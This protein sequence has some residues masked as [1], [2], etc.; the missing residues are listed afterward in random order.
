MLY[1]GRMPD[2]T[3]RDRVLSA[4]CVLEH[5]ADE[6]ALGGAVTAALCGHWDHEG[7]CRWPHHNE[8]STDADGITHV[9]T[10]VTLAE[11]D[12]AEV[13]RR[14]HDALEAGELTGPDGTVSRW[15]LVTA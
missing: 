9:R 2:D 5:D 3:A 7:P 4:D 14:F 15:R 12:D 11:A 10:T 8:S 13:R 6:R 1:P